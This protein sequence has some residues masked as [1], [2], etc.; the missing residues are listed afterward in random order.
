MVRGKKMKNP[1]R[2]RLPR[3]LKTEFGKYLVIFLLLVATIGLISGFLIATSSMLKAYND[4]FETYNVENGNFL[5]EKQANKAQIKN[6]EDAG[7]TLYENFYNEEALTNESTMR[8]FKDREEVN[9]VCLMKG[10][11]PTQT[12]EIAI[13]R[14]YADNNS[15]KVGDTIESADGK[16]S[17]KITGYVALPDYSCLFED[18]NDT[19]FDAV[20]FGVG[21][22]TP[23]GYAALANE[24]QNYSYS[25]KYRN[26][27]SDELQEKEMAEDLMD[28]VRDEAKLE[29]FIPRYLNQ[30]ITFTGDDFGSDKAM[31]TVL[32]YIIIVIMAFV[33]GV[34]VSNTI[35]KEANVIGT[36]RASGYTKGELVRHYMTMPLVVTLIGAL[37]GNILGY[38]V[39]K[40]FCA[41]MYYG[42]YSLPTYH[43]L[44]SVEAFWKTTLVPLALMA[45]VNAGILYTQ[46][47][48][49][50]EKDKTE[51]VYVKSDA[52]GNPREITVQTK[53]KNTSDGDTIEDYTN[54]TDIKNKEGDEAFTQNADGTI[55]WENHGEDITY[56]GTGSE[57][58]PVDVNISY[59][60]DG[61]PIE[62]EELAGKSGSLEIRFDYKN[63]TT[64]T[65]KIE[66]KEEQVSVPFAVISTMLLSEDHA[67]NIKVENGKVMDIDGQKL[68]VGYACP[69]LTKSLKLTTYEPTEDIDIPEYVEVMADVTDFSLDFTATIISSGLLE[70]MDLKDLDDVDEM[71]DNMKKLEEATDKLSDGAG[72]LE[73]G[74][75]TY[76]TYLDQYLSGVTALDQGAGALESGLQV[77]NE[78]KGDLQAGATLLK[79]SLTTLH[80]TLAAIQLPQGSSVDLSGME[81]A[82]K[83]LEA[84]ETKLNEVLTEMGTGLAE[85]QELAKE[86]AGYQATVKTQLETAKTALDVI[87]WTKLDQAVRADSQTKADAAIDSA[88]KKAL[89]NYGL[90]AEQIQVAAGEVK[91]E[92]NGALD[93]ISV[94]DEAKA[95]IKKAKEALEAIPTI[96][97][98]E[99]SLD[100]GKLT[101]TLNDMQKQMKILAGYSTTLGTVSQTAAAALQELQTGL[102]ALQTG[103]AQ[104]QEGSGQL[105]AGVSA[106]GAGIQQLYQGST[107]LHQGSGQ[108]SSA[109]T[110][111]ISGLDTMIS[112]MDS[113]HQ[114]LIKFDEDGIRELSDLTGKDLT[115]LA[116]RI[117]AL[118]KADGKYDNYGGIREGETGSVR[119]II[120]TDEIKAE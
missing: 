38:T 69:G 57:E 87:D 77:M 22:V 106:F 100:T 62:P 44:W 80:D 85:M 14:M 29:T 90:S 109:G 98:P 95:Q 37:I 15:L 48:D 33:F 86:A 104:L 81:T 39:F 4:G 83:Q 76:Q 41:G 108:L 115:N 52:K 79:E 28:V 26:E 47:K 111:L 60:L 82:A 107:A 67:S 53:L 91:T 88:M 71:S 65:I 20:K 101:E 24:Q 2:K 102:T 70:D 66:G 112:G 96:T 72:T 50:E 51:T 99:V 42:S 35:S 40:N 17:W 64:Q 74:M 63:K 105:E 117:R 12:D 84:D 36:L 78:K 89:E 10:E 9:T 3:E 13:D 59:E 56:E 18:N 7:V 31:M 45:V 58:L 46:K 93:Q 119:F 23:E 61:Q 116:N 11:M 97:I 27:P 5:L 103:T 34:T 54:L 120:E 94:S 113:L 118:K 110:A 32:L 49:T 43:T 16:Y 92:V 114:G 19:M 21:I 55:E 73:D 25:W 68:V 1:L 30:A 6:I 8:I 75:K